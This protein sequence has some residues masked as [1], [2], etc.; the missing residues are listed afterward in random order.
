MI[1]RLSIVAC[2]TCRAPTIYTDAIYP[3]RCDPPNLTAPDEARAWL[4]DEPTYRVQTIGRRQLLRRRAPS[5]QA[6]RDLTT[7]LQQST[8]R[9][10]TVLAPH[11]CP[12]FALPDLDL[13]T[14]Q[15]IDRHG[16][17][18]RPRPRPARD[19]QVPF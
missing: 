15:P 10:I 8:P 14:W 4:A 6:I 3:I 16:F 12:G 19:E 1:E 2:R 17:H 7:E 5:P 13:A 18:P 11:R 9:T